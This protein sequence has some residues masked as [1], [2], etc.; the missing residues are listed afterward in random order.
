[1][2]VGFNDAGVIACNL[3][4]GQTRQH[5]CLHGAPWRGSAEDSLHCRGWG[6]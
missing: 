4:A 2:M 6:R 1:M 5:D 3:N